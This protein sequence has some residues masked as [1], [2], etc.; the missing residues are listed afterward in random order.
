LH[1]GSQLALND[2]MINLNSI[3]TSI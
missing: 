1:I 3:M 2:D